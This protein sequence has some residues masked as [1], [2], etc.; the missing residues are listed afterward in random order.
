MPN[1]DQNVPPDS[2]PRANRVGTTGHTRQFRGRGSSLDPAN[3]FEK[4]LVELDLEQME[5]EEQVVESDRKI[6]TE[7]FLDDSTTV[8]SENHSPDV[9]FRFSLNPY[10]GCAHGCSYCYARPTHEY[11]GFNA[12]IDF[13]SKIV[14]KP[15]APKQFRKWLSRPKWRGHVEPV[16]LSGVTDCYQP[17]EKKFQLTRQCLEIALEMRQP[18][19]ITTKN[20]L[21]RR[22]LDLLTEM[23][24]LN[25]ITVAFSVCSLDQSL[26][27]VME[28][29]SSSPQQRLDTIQ[30]LAEAGVPVRVLVAPIIPG[31]ND[32]EI[33]DVLEQASAAGAQFAGYVMLRL[34]LSV[35]PVFLDWMDRNFPDRKQK[36]IGRIQSLREGKLNNSEFGSRMKGQGVWAETI[37]DLFKVYCAKLGLKRGN[38]RLDCD[39]FRQVQS[40]GKEQ[41]RLF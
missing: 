10:R 24:K 13:E 18:M 25:L 36:V 39:S 41:G 1:P 35:E 22:D 38:R 27:R 34:P 28:P 21:I 7:Y 17:C 32:D 12:G 6:K 31:I 3:R 33:P 9:D 15:N 40:D 5:L 30:S 19:M 4:I 26:I 14:V 20:G 37:A 16:M 8:V 2:T 23:A 29:R 11:L